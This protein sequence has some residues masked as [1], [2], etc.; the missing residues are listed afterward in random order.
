MKRLATLV[1]ALRG[2]TLGR[3]YGATWSVDEASLVIWANGV[4]SALPQARA[5]EHLEVMLTLWSR[6]PATDPP[7]SSH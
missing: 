7:G 4:T 5:L 1:D 2:M 3:A 6:L